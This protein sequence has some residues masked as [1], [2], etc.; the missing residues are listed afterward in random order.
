[1]KITW[2]HCRSYE[3]A[4]NYSRILYLHEWD[5]KPF[6]WGKVEN[7]FFGG[8]PRKRDGQ[9]LSGRYAPCYQHWIEGCLRHG[10]RLYVG[11]LDDEAM[12]CINELEKFLIHRYGSEMNRRIEP[13]GTHIAVQH[14]GDVPSCILQ[15]SASS[16]S[17]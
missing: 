15:R 4:K 2:V 17:P 3:D 12:Q 1:M 13:F 11:K 8:N 5:G 7:S 6:Y 14:E 16:V 9:Q 10:A